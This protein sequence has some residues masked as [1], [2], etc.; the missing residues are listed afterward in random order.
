MMIGLA[1][2]ASHI[3]DQAIHCN[4]ECRSKQNHF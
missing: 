2:A 1:F 4:L 3:V